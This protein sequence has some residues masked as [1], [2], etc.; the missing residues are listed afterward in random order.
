QEKI[1]IENIPLIIQQVKNSLFCMDINP[2]ACYLVE[3][4]LLIQVIDLLKQAKDQ[5]RLPDCTIDRFNVYN[6]D[7]LLLPKR[8]NIRTPLLNPVLN[9]E[10][11]IVDKIKTKSEEFSEGFDFIVGN[12]PY[13]RA[14][15]PGME[16]YRREIERTGRFETLHEKWDLFVPFVE[17][18]CKLTKNNGKIGLIVS[19][20]IQTNNYA[21]L[22]R[23]FVAENLKII[24][25]DF[26]NNVRL[27]TDAMVNNTIFFLENVKPEASNQV[28]RVLHTN[29]L[30]QIEPLEPLSQQNYQGQVFRQFI[31]THNLENVIDLEKICYCTKAMVLHSES[32]LFK[33]DDLLSLSSSKEHT[34]KYIDGENIIRN[35]AIDKIRYLEWGTERVPSQVS[36]VTIPELYDYPK[37]LFGMTSYPTYDRGLSHG[38]GFYVPD[39]VR[40]CIK[41]DTVFQ[42]KRLANE[43]RQMYEFSKKQQRILGE[44]KGKKVKIY[45]YAQQQ[46]NFSKNFDLRYIVAILASD[47]GKRFLLEN[48]RDE[49]IM[50]AGSDGKPAKSRIYPDDLKEFP[51]KNISLE[52]QQPLIDC[53]DI[54]V[55]GNWEIYQYCQEGHQIK[56]DYDPKEPQTKINSHPSQGRCRHPRLRRSAGCTGT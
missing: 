9:L 3:T 36:R 34:K 25:V 46:A 13:V 10:L 33:K 44:G 22:L 6:T 41:W 27:F 26:F 29:T 51:I 14:D 23:N 24:Q 21:E 54:L 43:R 38:D 16:N 18:S 35:F 45:E 55:E 47:C 8:E 40:F 4:N 7:S 52:K 31:N 2:F 1:P 56:F 5:G 32:G 50:R 20:A 53:V 37:I 42:I 12:P 49:N 19:R 48:N 15:E 11:L 39:S 28:Q 30:E 17:L